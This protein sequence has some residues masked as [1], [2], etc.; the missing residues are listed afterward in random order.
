MNPVHVLARGQAPAVMV[1]VASTRGSTPR[2]AGAHMLVRAEDF[3]G[4][5]GG[6]VLEHRAIEHA[7]ALLADAMAGTS[8]C[9]ASGSGAEWSDRL[10]L[11]ARFGQCCG[12]EAVL[13]FEV[14]ADGRG[15]WAPLLDAS[16][17]RDERWLSLVTRDVPVQ[18]TFV[19]E[20]RV[21]GPLAAESDQASAGHLMPLA[22]PPDHLVAMVRVR[23]AGAVGGAEIVADSAGRE[24]LVDPLGGERLPVTL[25]GAGHVGLALTTVLG[26]LPFDVTLIDDRP[27]RLPSDLPANVIARFSRA[28]ELEVGDLPAGSACLVMTYSHAL[29]RRICE[30]LLA[31]DDLRLVG[32]IG[33]GPKRRSFENHWRRK[34]M[35][36]ARMARLV[37][38]IGLPLPGVGKAPGM[39]AVAVAAQLI[40]LAQ[41]PD[42]EQ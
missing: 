37:C 10:T 11:G 31:R 38:P 29:D 21:L 5:I 16:V 25:F 32:L 42:T 14:L 8:G 41:R 35:S 17:G 9:G 2:E 40:G 18:R 6:G 30:H 24:Y 1:T 4:T 7:R 36:E 20:E 28:P 33:S 27:E 19:S 34:G 26:T 23:L 13:L 39:I 12:G 3:E 15:H 22:P